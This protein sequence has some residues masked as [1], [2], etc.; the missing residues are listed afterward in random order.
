MR[1][2]RRRP[3][4]ATPARSAPAWPRRRPTRF[5]PAGHGADSGWR[6]TVPPTIAAPGRPLPASSCRLRRRRTPPAEVEP[7]DGREHQ[8]AEKQRRQAD[9]ELHNDIRLP[10]LPS[11][12]EPGLYRCRGIRLEEPRGRGNGRLAHDTAVGAGHAVLRSTTA[13]IQDGWAAWVHIL[14]ADAVAGHGH[15]GGDGEKGN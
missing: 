9:H 8:R 14:V 13:R 1:Q 6:W 11:L 4:S 3:R 10:V 7:A 12:E 2:A 15:V 5:R